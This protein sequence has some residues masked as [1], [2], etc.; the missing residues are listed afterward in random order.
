MS[1]RA[2]IVDAAIEIVLMPSFLYGERL[3]DLAYSFYFPDGLRFRLFTYYIALL[4][5]V[6]VKLALN[7]NHMTP[8]VIIGT[9]R[10]QVSLSDRTQQHGE[11]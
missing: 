3:L 10:Q 1:S 11:L 8:L 6:S 5:R 7:S 4:I 2:G 9:V